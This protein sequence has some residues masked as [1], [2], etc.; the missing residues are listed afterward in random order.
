[1]SEDIH[2]EGKGYLRL[3]QVL[4]LIPVSKS[5]WWEGVKI[6]RYPQS[7]KIGPRT[8][9]WRAEDIKAFIEKSAA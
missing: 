7:I 9:V 3:K 8:T 4:Q 1:M 6:G 2:L 5:T